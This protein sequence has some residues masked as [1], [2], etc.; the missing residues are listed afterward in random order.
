MITATQ[1]KMAR[2]ALN[3]TTSDL[4][5]NA[6]V[7]RM[8]VARLE[9]GQTIGEATAAKIRAALEAGD[10]EFTATSDRVTVSA[11]R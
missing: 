2:V 11:P 9:L 1:S 3:W 6:G 7:G 10:V 8:T 4:A 5:H